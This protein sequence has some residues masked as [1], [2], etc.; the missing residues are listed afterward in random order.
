MTL[1]FA[2]VAF[3]LAVAIFMQQP[4]FGKAPA[5]ERLARIKRSP[6]Y[7]NG[8]FQN[9]SPT[10]M[11]TDGANYLS[12]LGAFFFGGSP[13]VKPRD[14]IPHLST[15]L[16]RLPI[17]DNILVWFGHSSYFMQLD[18]K[19]VLVDP[20]LSGGASPL[21]FTTRSFS[22]T[23]VYK[24]ADLPEIDY[25][26]IT[27]D[28]WDHLD[29]DT[30]KKLKAK[31]KNVICPLGVGAHLEYWGYDAAVIHEEDWGQAM[32]LD[33]GFVVHTTP[34]RHFSGRG[35]RRNQSLWTSY[36]LQTPSL[37]IFIGGD[38]GYD[39]HFAKI[40]AQFGGFDLAILEN[41]QYNKAWKHIHTLPHEVLQAAGDLNAKNIL[42]IHSS[43][44]PLSTH[45]WD[46]PLI[47]VV[48]ANKKAGF[49]LITP[50]IGQAVYLDD[51]TQTFTR[52]WEG[53]R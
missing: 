38:S 13:R 41:G 34:A 10:P 23:D 32:P 27:H 5:G 42:P 18:G 39:T 7:K 53:L 11:M 36:V 3:A 6:N 37:R 52:W 47:N 9:L 8:A 22:G 17:E 44:F 40:G 15:D 31:V 30:V 26:F 28:H 20:V 35:F 49:R 29:Y 12:V 4:M 19:R 46:E 51:S 33:D 16:H 1:F 2:I 24:V 45:A 48:E 50:L 14:I 43:K 25:L 21:S